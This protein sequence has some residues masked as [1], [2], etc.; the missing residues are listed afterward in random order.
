MNELDMMMEE[1]MNDPD[2]MEELERAVEEAVLQ[3]IYERGDRP[4]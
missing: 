3:Q 1:L 4:Y 2:F